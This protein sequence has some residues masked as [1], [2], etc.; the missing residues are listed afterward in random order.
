MHVVAC[1]IH[2]ATN[3]NQLVEIVIHD[4]PRIVGV[5]YAVWHDRLKDGAL[6]PDKIHAQ[7]DH[8]EAIR[9]YL[10]VINALLYSHPLVTGLD[11]QGG[12]ELPA[13]VVS[14]MD[15][16]SHREVRETPIYR[17][18]YRHLEIEN[19]AVLEFF[20][21]GG[22]GAMICVNTNRQLTGVQ[23]TMIQ[24][25]RDHLAVAYE[26]LSVKEEREQKRGLW[27]F[28]ATDEQLTAREKEVLPLVLDGKTN[29]EIAVIL[30]ISRRTVEK[31]VSAIIRKAGMENR[32]MLIASAREIL[33]SD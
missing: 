26:K 22:Q 12:I 17:D 16:A 8:A 5:G 2:R 3:V 31:H 32:K 23:M 1:E 10:P 29:H 28:P 11:M 24:V 9:H 18:A 33:G 25:V 21:D 6:E 4:L 20:T 13:R 15:F 19:H 27:S 30:G 7:K 14:T